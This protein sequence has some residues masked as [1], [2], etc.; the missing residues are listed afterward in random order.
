MNYAAIYE[1]DCANG[2]GCRTSLFVS[3]CTHH[4]RGCFNEE[5][6]DFSYGKP[7]DQEVEDYVA[8]TLE[9]SHIDGLSVLGGEPMEIVNQEALLPLLKRA[10]AMNKTIWIYSGYLFEEL[11]DEGNRRCHGPHTQEILELIDVLVDGEFVLEKKNISLRF[12]GS[13]NQRI[14]DVPR[15]LAA[16]EPILLM[17]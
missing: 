3:G 10:K 4:C 2:T 16:K 9:P 14:L 12:R 15:S 5:A 6:W 17:E 11:T 13:E 7:F 1:V 8:S